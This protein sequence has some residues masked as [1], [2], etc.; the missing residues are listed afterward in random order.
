MPTKTSELT[1]DSGFLT[2]HQSLSDYY[3][4]QQTDDI[5][6]E[7]QDAYELFS[8]NDQQ[9]IEGDG[10]VYRLSSDEWVN[11]GE[12]AL[13][14]DISSSM[15]S[16][17]EEYV[18]EKVTQE[19]T[20]RQAA[21]QELRASIGEKANIDQIPTKTSQLTNDS[22]FIGTEQLSDY[23]TKQ[24]TDEAISSAL[25]S[26]GNSKYIE[27]ED[28][29]QRIYGNRDVRTLSSTPGTYGPWT[30]EEG[31]VDNEWRVV[32]IS[33]GVFCYVHGDDYS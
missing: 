21:D 9:K 33:A 11:I 15:D 18:D 3:T 8:R 4:K 28:G 7:K 13:K 16:A 23:Y 2:A 19:A 20:A 30:D 5:I 32:E 26:A 6:A 14:S 1:N 17:T 22:G 12:L 10:L 24:Q 27:S 25:S 29:T 31:N